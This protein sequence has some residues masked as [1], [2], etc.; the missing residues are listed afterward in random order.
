MARK[1]N[2]QPLPSFTKIKHFDSEAEIDR[3]VEK[4]TRCKTLLDELW[5]SQAAFD[6]PRTRTLEDRIHTTVL[7]IFGPNSP[8]YGRDSHHQIWHGGQY[9]GMPKHEIQAGFRAGFPHTGVR[10]K[11][12]MDRLEEARSDLGRD[13]TART[14]A[15]F[16]GLELHPRIGEA[17]RELYG[18]GHYGQS[19]LDGSI[20]LVN[21]V[22]E[23]SRRHDLVGASLM[24]TVLSPNKP[25]LAFNG[26]SNQME[27]DEQEGFMHLFIGAV[28]ALRNPRAHA[29]F[30]DSP[31]IALDYVAFLSLLAKRLDGAKRI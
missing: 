30:D 20:A 7:E 21:Y 12:L 27:K 16:E 5:D 25:I 13:S 1:G 24:S 19:V 2:S 4:L 23:K 17:A 6:D 10:L 14:R 26:L 18:D 29:I 15:A 11:S 28:L 8:E 9:V 3:G 31:E 22:K